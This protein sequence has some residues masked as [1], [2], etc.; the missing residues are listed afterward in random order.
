MKFSDGFWLNRRGFTVNY[1]AQP[2]EVSVVRNSIRVFATSSQIYN[3]AMTLG[4]VTLEVVFSS[5]KKDT[6]KVHI[7]HHKG[8]AN[9]E[10]KFELYEDPAFVPEIIDTETETI[11][12][13]RQN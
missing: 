9:H 8:A 4:G 3:R 6:I 7:V 5:T 11:S 1:A 10:P 2:Y 13:L 12:S